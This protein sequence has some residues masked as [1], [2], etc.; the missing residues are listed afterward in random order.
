MNENGD[1]ETQRTMVE[2]V[3]RPRRNSTSRVDSTEMETLLKKRV[4]PETICEREFYRREKD[5]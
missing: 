5:S 4:V 2:E 3:E 1:L